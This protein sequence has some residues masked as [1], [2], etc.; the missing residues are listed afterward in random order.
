M[1]IEI[2]NRTYMPKKMMMI[3]KVSNQIKNLFLKREREGEK[4]FFKPIL[5]KS[6]VL[7]REKKKK[8]RTRTWNIF[9]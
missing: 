5:Q 6:Y 1:Y 8:N 2:N 7:L 4:C 3:Y 9:K